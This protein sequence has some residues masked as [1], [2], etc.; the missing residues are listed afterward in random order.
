MPEEQATYHTPQTD[1]PD[2]TEA[3]R[4][5]QRTPTGPEKRWI[6]LLWRIMPLADV[7]ARTGIAYPTLIYWQSRGY[8]TPIVHWVA[9][10]HPASSEEKKWH[11]KY[12]LE[13]GLDA[14]TVARYMQVSPCTIYKYKNA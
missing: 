9:D 3:P 4:S 2:T 12:L 13:S 11:A 8:I 7:A 6:D 10:V 5:E 1:M 14:S